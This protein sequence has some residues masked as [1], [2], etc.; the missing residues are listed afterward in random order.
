MPSTRGGAARIACHSFAPNGVRLLV[1]CIGARNPVVVLWHACETAGG[2]GLQHVG[3]RRR[4]SRQQRLL[5]R[6][7]VCCGEDRS[8]VSVASMRYGHS[9]GVEPGVRL[10]Q[11]LEQGIPLSS[12]STDVTG[13]QEV[14]SC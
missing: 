13:P 11:G 6:R 10:L 8:R 3:G 5:G 2:D 1:L 12:V 9:C 14:E 7:E 4:V